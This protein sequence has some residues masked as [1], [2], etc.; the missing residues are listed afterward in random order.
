MLLQVL[1][2]VLSGT[3]SRLCFSRVYTYTCTQAHSLILLPAARR[4]HRA[5]VAAEAHEAEVEASTTPTPSTR[6][7]ASTKR[8][9]R[10]AF[11]FY[12]FFFSQFESENAT[13]N[14]QEELS[15][16][17]ATLSCGWFPTHSHRL[18]RSLAV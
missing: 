3:C 14:E 8:A 12:S 2:L 17:T 4:L 6:Q 5:L 11:M 18:L 1:M 7:V 16:R 15:G 10:S 9:C 13:A